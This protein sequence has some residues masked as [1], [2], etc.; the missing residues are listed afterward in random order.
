MGIELMC[1]QMD[2]ELIGSAWAW[3]TG[4]QRCL[5]VSGVMVGGY[6]NKGEPSQEMAR[7]DQH[8]EKNISIYGA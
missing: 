7:E 1:I 6:K 8:Q 4:N 3:L 2:E 5:V